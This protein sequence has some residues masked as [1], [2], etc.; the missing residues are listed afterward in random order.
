M[1]LPNVDLETTR[2][3]VKGCIFLHTKPRWEPLYAESPELGCLVLTWLT[4][5]LSIS[6]ATPPPETKLFLKP[7]GRGRVEDLERQVP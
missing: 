3:I 7:Q 6:L 1:T 4:M 5:R 2:H